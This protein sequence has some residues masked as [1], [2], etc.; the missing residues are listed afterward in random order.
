[1]PCSEHADLAHEG[2]STAG[3][4]MRGAESVAKSSGK[5]SQRSVSHASVVDLGGEAHGTH[6]AFLPDVIKGI[7]QEELYLEDDAYFQ[8]LLARYK[9][10]VPVGA[11][12]TEPR[13]K[14][15]REQMRIRAG[16]LAVDTRKLHAAEE[17]AASRM[18][19]LYPFVGSAPLGVAL[20]SIPV[21]A[22]EEFCALLLKREEA[23][24]GK[25]G[26]VHEVESALS[27][28]AEA[29]AKAVLEEEEALA[30]AFPFLGRS[31]KGAPLRELA[32]MSDPNFAELATRHAQEATSG[33]AAGILRLEQELRDQACRI[34]REVRVARRLD[35]VRNEDLHER[36]PFLPE[37][38]VRGILL[39]AVR[40]VQQPAF[41]ELSNKLDEQRRDPTRNA[42]AIRTTEEQ[43]TA[44]VV[45]LAE[46]RAEATER[47]H[48]QYPFLPRRVLGVRLGDIS[49]QEDDVLSHLERRRVRQL[50]NSKTAIDAHA[51]EEEMIRR[52]EELA[53]N[54][55]LVDAY[56][57]NGNEYVRARNPFLVYEDRKCVLLSELPLA[58]DGVYQ[59]L[60]RDYL[61][62]LEDAEANAP[63]IAEL[64]NALRSR[65]DELALEVCER[66][67]RLSHYSFLSAQDVP[68]WS[69]ALLHDA[70]FQQLRERYDELSKDPQG[71]AEALRE[72]EDAMEARSRAIAEALRTAEAT[73]ATEQARLKTPSQAGSGVSAGDR[74]HGSE[75]AD[76]AHEGGSTAGG[77]MRGA[78]SVAK[79]SGKHTQRSVSHASVVDLGGEA[80]GTHY[81]FLP[82]VIKGI[83]QEELYL[84]DDA[85]FQELLARYKE[86]VPV[87]AEPT[88]PRAKQLREQMRI[89]A[90]QLAVDTRKLHAAEERAASRMATLYPFVGSA[91]LGV[92]L[93]NIPVEADEEFCALLLKREEALA[94][95][96]GSVHEVESALSA[97][98]EAMAKAV[99][100]EEEALAAAFPFLGRSVK[101]APLRELALMSDP[102][103]AELATRHA[104]EATSGDA[105]GILR[106]EQELRDQACR[107]A[108]EVRVAR[109]LDA[110]RNEDL[111]ER[112]PFLPEEP[113]RGILLGAVRPVQQP[114]FRE[115]SN[116][117]DEQRRDP[118]RNAAAIRTTEEQMTALVVRLAE[119][120]AEATE[121]AHE[122]YPFLPRRVLGVRLGDISLQEDDVLS[123]LARRRV[124][125]QRYTSIAK[126]V[127]YTEKEMIRRAEELARNVKLV[128][129]Y[130]GNGNEYVRARNPFL[131]YE[132][133]KCVLLSELPLAG[134][135]VYQGLFRDYLTALEDAEANAPR[136]AEL[137]NA[138][139]SRADELALE[140]CERDA[141]LSHY[142]FLSAQ[143]VPGWSEALLHDAEFQQLRERYD[144]LSKD[145]QGNAEALR[146]LEDA[147]EA[148]SRAIAEALRTAEA[149]NATE[150]ARL[151]ALFPMCADLPVS[152]EADNESLN[153]LRRRSSLLSDAFGNSRAIDYIDRSLRRRVSLLALSPEETTIEFCQESEVVA[154]DVRMNRNVGKH[155][156]L[157]HTTAANQRDGGDVRGAVRNEG[158]AAL[159]EQGA[160]SRVEGVEL[161]SELALKAGENLAAVLVD[162][163]EEVER[164]TIQQEE[165]LRRVEHCL[166]A[167]D[168]CEAASREGLMMDEK[169]ALYA[170]LLSSMM[171]Q[172]E[173]AR[174]VV[175]NDHDN[176]MMKLLHEKAAE[177]AS[178][179]RNEELAAALCGMIGEESD[180]RTRLQKSEENKRNALLDE[181]LQLEESDLRKLVELNEVQL[182]DELM[183]EESDSRRK[184]ALGE[185]DRES[186]RARENLCD[187][188]SLDRNRLHDV[189]SGEMD[190]L[191][192]MA[193]TERHSIIS[194][195]T[196]EELCDAEAQGRIGI[197]ANE[198]E[199]D[200]ELGIMKLVGDE[201]LL[202]QEIEEEGEHLLA[203]T[204]NAFDELCKLMDTLNE[205]LLAVGSTEGEERAKLM[206]EENK[207]REQIT[208]EVE[209][210][211]ATA[212]D[213]TINTLNELLLTVKKA[214]REERAKLMDE[215]NIT[216]GEALLE[217]EK[218]EIELRRRRKMEEELHFAM[219]EEKKCRDVIFANEQ[220]DINLLRRELEVA[221][222]VEE[223]VAKMI[224]S[225]E[226]A[227][228]SIG[229]T[230][231]YEWGQLQEEVGK[232]SLEAIRAQEERETVEKEAQQMKRRQD[233]QAL[234]KSVVFAYRIRRRLANRFQNRK[235]QENKNAIAEILRMEFNT[236][237]AICDEERL[238][239]QKIDEAK[240][241]LISLTGTRAA[242]TIA[243]LEKEED[244]ARHELMDDFAFHLS[245][246][247]RASRK[248]LAKRQDLIPS[249]KQLQ[250]FEENE[251]RMHATTMFTATGR[252]VGLPLSDDTGDEG[253]EEEEFDTP[254]T[255]GKYKGYTLDSIGT[256]L[257]Q[258]ER[259]LQRF[260]ASLEKHRVIVAADHDMLKKARDNATQDMVHGG[261]GALW[262]PTRPLPLSDLVRG[263]SAQYRRGR[264]VDARGQRPVSR[265]TDAGGRAATPSDVHFFDGLV[266]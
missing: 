107:I 195:A 69:E 52:A 182:L 101:G 204:T 205:M 149:T 11:E 162:G 35:A 48:E 237:S 54:V 89:R 137:E 200:V 181:W 215:E 20:W 65:A 138:L 59:G 124:R 214:E 257:L 168:A 251:D 98:A 157:R 143:D 115:L 258:Y 118:T 14:Q 103:F 209:E 75:H 66:D 119:E 191:H 53:R 174:N 189:E 109:R 45:R 78:E 10:L 212:R 141:R 100:E 95:K 196:I 28:R 179:C 88:E 265:M 161:G 25:S 37:E 133:R 136:I 185:T 83:A 33:D 22:D 262:I 12:P 15:L 264:I 67:A 47:A 87:G 266:K 57:G 147:M 160:K 31:V 224:G 32:L 156:R 163:E 38:P 155:R 261:T 186:Y 121:R 188:E 50:R 148:R 229:D 172:E 232:A 104:Q 3:G 159:E 105:A 13:A 128:D 70:E 243:E 44:L 23:L 164:R 117:L 208:L 219:D 36:Y 142:S 256:F 71:N 239:C 231:E 72:L 139:R 255:T 153:L 240:R 241:S 176:A 207:A 85:Y 193:L 18:A 96:S 108:R 62:A 235:A 120:R 27:A 249:L 222:A 113:V 151:R 259:D 194:K 21:E 39:G 93:W 165:V 144:E 82:D 29:M 234:I 199:G 246:L 55:K 180:D 242:R 129:A 244:D 206:D 216:R 152:M 92:A 130:R 140:V 225:E 145:P 4:T 190:D 154:F 248:A 223:S 202:R 41:R 74:M 122:Q 184:A 167:V 170:Q 220:E 51:T 187:E 230:E 24:A 260:K 77:T 123:Q 247:Q 263:P 192:K 203:S 7:A 5:H 173:L 80:H 9:E 49:L 40:P 63:R 250:E 79:S 8:E 76:L 34:A 91:P 61:T 127:N 126:D 81:A 46:E 84:E 68:G 110:V 64:E 99:L 90:G 201:M 26:S 111:H 42:A 245:Q 106:L 228:R 213:R 60:F 178:V 134:D 73:N 146:E 30:A 253:D 97:R 169:S 218:E 2:G 166:S 112:Y 226:E 1:M 227:R 233:A 56:R 183:L 58:G 114:A 221:I 211:K 238:E 150:Q 236:R 198:E 125:Q 86:L 177:E 6:Y 16:Q 19:T 131:V 254:L 171:E 116:K 252:K 132:D 210:G 17:R 197:T 135:G 102:N 175:D 94:G 158:E 43:M 217:A